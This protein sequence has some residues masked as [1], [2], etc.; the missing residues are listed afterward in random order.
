MR[1]FLSNSLFHIF[2][3]MLLASFIV[4]MKSHE[5]VRKYRKC[6]PHLHEQ[7]W[8]RIAS[9]LDNST[10][11]AHLSFTSHLH[12]Q[13]TEGQLWFLHPDRNDPLTIT[14][15]FDQTMKYLDES[16]RLSIHQYIW[17][18]ESIIQSNVDR[19]QY[20]QWIYQLLRYSPLEYHKYYIGSSIKL[21]RLSSNAIHRQ[22]SLDMIEIL[23]TEDFKIS[24]CIDFQINSDD[25]VTVQSSSEW[26][27]LKCFIYNRYT[28][29][30]ADRHT[31][32]ILY[33][34]EKMHLISD[35]KILRSIVEPDFENHILLKNDF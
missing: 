5:H 9:H 29:K 11:A 26:D 21:I 32:I 28:K 34:P 17:I 25:L 10:D 27:Q 31:K 16:S 3:L 20:K 15:Q 1:V 35:I 23:H 33:N 4:T 30:E 12:K 6:I 7:I 13:A 24:D 19:V 2:V 22:R 14:N 18:Y 8:A